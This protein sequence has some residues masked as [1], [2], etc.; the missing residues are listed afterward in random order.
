MNKTIKNLETL[1]NIQNETKNSAKNDYWIEQYFDK[2]I[3]LD[4]FYLRMILAGPQIGAPQC[5]KIFA[6]LYNFELVPPNKNRGDMKKNNKYFEYK[7]SGFGSVNDKINIRQIRPWQK[8][9][10]IFQIIN[11]KNHPIFVV[12][13]QSMDKFIKTEGNGVFASHGTK[14]INEENTY[15]EYCFSLS[16]EKFM[17]FFNKFLINIPKQ[18]FGTK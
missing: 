5:E 17:D 18:Y 8:C 16:Y 13:K 15:V 2:E 1:I 4:E 6:K 7:C 3:S 12:S 9:N 11:Q 10:Y 14:Q